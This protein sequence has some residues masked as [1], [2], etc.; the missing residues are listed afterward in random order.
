MSQPISPS[1]L[2]PALLSPSPDV[3]T[4]AIT[5]LQQYYDDLD[6]RSDAL[7][8]LLD[9]YP[10]QSVGALCASLRTFIAEASTSKDSKA[11]VERAKWLVRCFHDILDCLCQ[12]SSA[13]RPLLQAKHFLNSAY[14]PESS[15]SASTS[16]SASASAS[17]KGNGVAGSSGTAKKMRMSELVYELWNLMTTALAV[18][19]RRTP[20][21]APSFSREVMVDWMRDALIFGRQMTEHLGSFEAAVLGGGSSGTDNG[22]VGGVHEI[23]KMTKVGKKL[24]KQAQVV[25]VDL[26][27]WFRLTE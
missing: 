19:F 10:A 3:H 16:A 14:Y 9:R 22:G 17:A 5:S 11:C 21:W 25:L 18:I 7:R 4:S 6:D 24:V 13:S 12:P 8:T 20:K 26:V 15:S 1:T 2:I 23:G 27:S